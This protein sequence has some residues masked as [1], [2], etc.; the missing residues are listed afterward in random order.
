MEYTDRAKFEK[1][2]KEDNYY[3]VPMSVTA[4]GDT[5]LEAESFDPPPL[6]FEKKSVLAELKATPPTEHKEKDKTTKN[7]EMER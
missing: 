7:K 2:V 3:G 1:Q 6:G 4:Y 5:T